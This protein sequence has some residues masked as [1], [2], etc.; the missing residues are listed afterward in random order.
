MTPPGFRFILAAG[1]GLVASVSFAD[2]D[3][4][5]EAY[6]RQDYIQAAT[7]FDRFVTDHASD[8]RGVSAIY[9]ASLCRLKLDQPRPAAERLRSILGESQS[10]AAISPSMV[11]LALGAA[12]RMMLDDTQAVKWIESA[13]LSAENT[14]ER[15]AARRMLKPLS[16]R[17]SP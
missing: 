3:S 17:L 12:C 14:F 15:A 10:P 13:W 2:Y 4:A 7:Q 11:R 6:L 16:P 5:L 1:M 8:S 9:Y